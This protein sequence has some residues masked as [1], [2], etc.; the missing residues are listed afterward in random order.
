[1]LIYK[2]IVNFVYLSRR[3]KALFRL[4]QTGI[5]DDTHQGEE[6]AHQHTQL[7]AQLLGGKAQ[8]R[9]Q[10]GAGG[11]GRR[12]IGDDA[13]QLGAHRRAH[14]TTR[15]HHGVNEHAAGG[16]PG[17]G[18]DQTAGPQHGH[19]K[20]CEGAGQKADERNPRQGR[21]EVAGRGA[22]AAGQK[23]PLGVFAPLGVQGATQPQHDR[24]QRH[25]EDVTP[26]LG[27]AHG[28]LQI[29]GAPLAHGAL[30][31]AAAKDGDHAEEHLLVFEQGQGTRYPLGGIQVGELGAEEQGGGG[32]GNEGAEKGQP[33]PALLAE[34]QKEQGGH[35][36][37]AHHAPGVDGVKLTHLPI[38]ILG[39]DGGDDGADE[40]LAK[41]AGQGEDH[42]A[43]DEARVDR[44]G[45]EEGPEG[46]DDKAQGGEHG[47]DLDRGGDVELV[48]EEGEDEVHDQL[49]EEIDENQ[50]AQQGVGYA[51]ELMK[52]QKEHGGEVGYHRHGDV[53][54]VACVLD[55]LECGHGGLLDEILPI[56]PHS[57]ANVNEF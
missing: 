15:R 12:G 38:G 6:H 54:G 31:R 8:A 41:A 21:D 24:E 53:G 45:E 9:G 14:V 56:V 47:G 33:L 27:D 10:G 48:G 36:D 37:H 44:G 26:D 29:P 3:A 35:Q 22:D 13:H 7:H 49:G 50:Q 4:E 42:R 34:E 52:G 19:A 39:G 46:I 55:A 57:G 11:I 43:E 18:H 28:R 20:A 2:S 51:V 1:M 16:H 40:H 5:D 17:G 23:H 30:R 32:N 25:A